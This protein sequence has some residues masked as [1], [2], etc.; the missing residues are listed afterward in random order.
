MH[1][2]DLPLLH[3]K[4][5]ECVSWLWD[6]SIVA[7]VQFPYQREFHLAICSPSRFPQGDRK[8]RQTN[9]WNEAMAHRKQV[10]YNFKK[11]LFLFLFVC[12]SQSS[13]LHVHSCALSANNAKTTNCRMEWNEDGQRFTYTCCKFPW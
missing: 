9:M 10:V 6:Q 7:I 12:L 3:N 8:F 13:W 2:L 1:C 5:S 4:V 11:H